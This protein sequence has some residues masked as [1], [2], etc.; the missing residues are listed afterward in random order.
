MAER[1]DFDDGGWDAQDKQILV[2]YF[3]H[4]L[5]AF[6][7]EDELAE[8]I[9]RG[10]LLDPWGNDCSY[11]LAGEAESLICNRVEDSIAKFREITRQ[12]TSSI[13]Q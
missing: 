10:R 3:L 6:G 9:N 8:G 2:E 1:Y 13:E 7:T 12:I 5:E 11:L 4:Q